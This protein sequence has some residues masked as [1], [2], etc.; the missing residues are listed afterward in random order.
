ML[1]KSF[2]RRIGRQL[3]IKKKSLIKFDLPKY[4]FNLDELNLA[5]K[6]NKE[7]F[8]EIGFGMGHHL[9]A[10]LLKDDQNLYIGAEP[11]MNGVGDLLDIVVTNNIKNVRIIPDTIDIILDK[12]NEGI[13]SCIYLLFPDPWTKR[14]QRKN[15]IVNDI[16]AKLFYK[17]IKKDGI[18][19]FASDIEDYIKDVKIIMS[20]AGFS[21]IDKQ[22]PHDSYVT[23]KYHEKA[24]KE[25]RPVQFLYFMK[26]L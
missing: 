4:H 2:A 1:N 5:L 13:I 6:T 23:T 21:I 16:R 8:L 19:I 17:I 22:E 26:K 15:R 7:V 11:Y 9:I 18:L 14:K 25:K 24:I 12:L 10:Q 20:D 3:S